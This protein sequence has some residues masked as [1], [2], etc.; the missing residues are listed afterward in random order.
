[1][2]ET[3]SWRP[4]EYTVQEL[5]KFAEAHNTNL[6]RLIEES[7]KER[8]N[9]IV[10]AENGDVADLL[11]FE[12]S[13]VVNNFIGVRMVKP[14]QAIHEKIMAKVKEND[15]KG[16]WV[17]DDLRRKPTQDVPGGRGVVVKAVVGKSK[18]SDSRLSLKHSKN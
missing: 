9:K 3:Y 8:I 6:N 12:I 13:K 1:M 11:T 4:K 10:L 17:T 5:Q 7:V 14:E 18:G 16:N 15:K 2:S